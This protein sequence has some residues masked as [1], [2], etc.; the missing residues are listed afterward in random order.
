MP[1]TGLLA[2]GCVILAINCFFGTSAYPQRTKARI[3]HNRAFHKGER[4]HERILYS[5]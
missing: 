2:T 3:I 5:K 4:E 1:S